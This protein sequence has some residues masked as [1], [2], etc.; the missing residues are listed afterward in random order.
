MPAT[1]RSDSRRIDQRAARHLRDQR[2]EAGHGENKADVDLRPF[3]RGQIDRDERP[4]TGLHV[5]DEEDE[6]VEAAQAAS[7]GRGG[8]SAVLLRPS[9]CRFG[10]G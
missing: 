8:G 3:L 4:E 7:R 2:D 1:S 9:A 6:P 5:G 10:G